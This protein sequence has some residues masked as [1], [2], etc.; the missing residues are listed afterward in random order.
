[1]ALARIKHPNVVTLLA[2]DQAPDG[3]ILVTE[4]V[5]GT[6]LRDLPV[7]LD[8]RR[9]AELVRA[10]ADGLAAVHA[11]GVLHRDL[12]PENAILR[13]DGQPIL[14]DFGL[15]R[16]QDARTLTADGTLLGT[17]AYM[18]PEQLGD[19][20]ELDARA[21][22]Y[23]L[24]GVLFFLLAGR[25]PY[26]GATPIEVLSKVTRLEP[27]WPEGAPPGLL[28]VLR[29]AMAREREGRPAS[30]AALRDEL[31]AWLGGGA[32]A[33]S[34]GGLL[35]GALLTLLLSM[36][37]GIGVALLLR[38]A[39]PAPPA[40]PP[41]STTSPA[42]VPSAA[43]VIEAPPTPSPAVEE[44]DADVAALASAGLLPWELRSKLLRSGEAVEGPCRRD[45][46]Q[47]AM[48]WDGERAVVWLFGG[49]ERLPGANP[50]T[51]PLGDLWSW[52]GATWTQHLVRDGPPARF[53]H[54]VVHDPRRD[55]LVV[56]GGFQ[57]HAKRVYDAE[58]WELELGAESRRWTH[59]RP[60]GRGPGPR[61]YPGAAWS[62]PRGATLVFGGT[63]D[64][65]GAGVVSDLWSWDGRA[66][67]QVRWTGEGPPPM[68]RG[69]MAQDPARDRLFLFGGK[70]QQQVHGDLWIL[71]GDR[72][73]RSFPGE[74][75]PARV[76]HL[77]VHDGR[78][79]LVAGG[80]TTP[81]YD[82][83]SP[84]GGYLDDTR[85]YEDGQWRR[86]EPG[87]SPPRRT[88]GGGCYD[89]ARREVVVFGGLT[90]HPVDRAR[91]VE[92]GTWVYR[93]GLLP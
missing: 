27:A 33:R 59:R 40:P 28:A 61:M 16:E 81:G 12:K 79:L 20:R 43:P 34:R 71:E 49:L 74:D 10:L 62:E 85:V 78:R 45:H 13:A 84:D 64:H 17:P 46:I 88:S 86:L 41:A 29:R 48:T 51:R 5:H 82:E 38:K 63:C 3:P 39:A 8:P 67:T 2:Y 31:G 42:P 66:W 9:A 91:A 54:V 36:G 22:V 50:P 35:A 55:V 7:P 15:S 90:Y 68:V 44:V 52:D 76:G 58:V 26:E 47:T 32:R 69:A 60:Q 83:L 92:G 25:P 19:S 57:D 37:V 14:I 11:A 23:G 77:L 87:Q 18:A 72:W 73:S 93:L 75:C 80:S 70:G 53:G 4:L 6:S 30:A 24:A 56:L 65:L 21:D 1:M 89:R